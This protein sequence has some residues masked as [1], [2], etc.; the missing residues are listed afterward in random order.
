MPDPTTD[1]NLLFGILAVRNAFVTRE[2]LAAAMSDW[3]LDKSRPLG[4]I[5]VE[6]GDLSEVENA[7]LR[8]LLATHLAHYHED[9]QQSLTAMKPS[10]DADPVTLVRE[11]LRH[12]PD[13][14]L[15]ASLDCTLCRTSGPDTPAPGDSPPAPAARR[16]PVRFCILRPHARG[17]L[18]QVFVAL[19]EELHRE[20]ALKEIQAAHAHDPE[21]RARF[22]LEAEITGRLE[23]PGIVPVYGLGIYADGRP[24]YAMRF[25]KG[26]SLKDAIARFHQAEGAQ[27]DPGARQVELRGLLARFVDVCNAV[28][29]AHSRGVLHRDLKPANVMLGQY[30]ETL[31]V[32][33]GLAKVL[34]KA[35][36]EPARSEAALAP[37]TGS[38]SAPTQMGR[39]LGTPAYMSPEQAAGQLDRLG[40]PT[41][42][43]SLGATLYHLLT[44]KAAFGDE[45]VGSVLQ[46]VERGEF[47]PPRR[48]NRRARRPLRRCA[49]RRWRST[50]RSAT[51]RRGRWPTTSSAGWPT[52]RWRRFGSRWPPDCAA[53]CGGTGRW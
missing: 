48:V 39:A 17:G 50:R 8:E 19:D 30:G 33:W 24:F 40:Q 49:S 16:T 44:G 15:Q 22:V 31:V 10:G 38:A 4:E 27:R 7:R 35:E 26:D 2:R 32:D 42:V 28:A 11:A 25:I 3:A 12:V 13:A 53:G 6:R 37:A 23:H 36:A 9:P 14:D 51:L 41:D 43:Y 45:D 5:L 1:R 29:Y 34:G 21:S 46:K 18:G 52:S 47:P 20:V